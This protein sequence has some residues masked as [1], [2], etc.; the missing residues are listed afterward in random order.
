M[1]FKDKVVA[2][3]GGSRGF[4]A[5]LSKRFA[6]EGAVISICARDKEA[7]KRVSEEIEQSGG[8]IIWTKCDITKPDD[9]HAFV[10]A[11]LTQLGHVDILINNAG[12]IVFA[13]V[14]ET[15]DEIWDFMM[16]ANL[17]SVRQ[18]HPGIFTIY[19][20]PFIGEDHFYL[21]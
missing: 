3:T 17:N 5:A 12:A 9:I 11:T 15:T 20:C 6:E 1:R 14:L 18:S 16:E 4:G 2:I 8:N 19:A 10:E 21:Q 7:L 13:P